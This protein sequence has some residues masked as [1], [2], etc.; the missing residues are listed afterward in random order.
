MKLTNLGVAGSLGVNAPQTLGHLGRG[1]LRLEEENCVKVLQSFVTT[2][3]RS[4]GGGRSGA[5]EECDLV[6]EREKIEERE[7]SFGDFA[8]Y[9]ES[10][11][12]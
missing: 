7:K 11:L 5:A 2:C 4:G 6:G 3:C 9:L 8:L 1:V 10:F 12:P